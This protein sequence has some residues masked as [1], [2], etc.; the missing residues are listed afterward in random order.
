MHT[1]QYTFVRHDSRAMHEDG[2]HKC[3]NSHTLLNSTLHFVQVM[4]L[5]FAS[6]QNIELFP[7]R[8]QSSNRE[9]STRWE[10]WAYSV[11]PCTS[12]CTSGSSGQMQR[13]FMKTIDWRGEEDGDWHHVCRTKGI[14]DL[15]NKSL[16]WTPTTPKLYYLLSWHFSKYRP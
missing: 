9:H 3:W 11:I 12:I 5:S 10:S 13:E 6:V 1:L 16:V 14:E 2:L 15:V 7:L 4:L 8:W